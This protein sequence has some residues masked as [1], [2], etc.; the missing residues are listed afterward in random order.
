MIRKLFLAAIL[1]GCGCAHDVVAQSIT[2]VSNLGETPFSALA[3]RGIGS[4]GGPNMIGGEFVTG[5]ASLGYT[6]DSIAVLMSDDNG[7]PGGGF[8]VSV[9]TD[10]SGQPG[11]IVAML[12]GN[13]D[14]AMAGTYTYTA[15]GTTLFPLTSYWVVET[16]LSA[17]SDPNTFYLWSTTQSTSFAS[18]EGWSIVTGANEGSGDGGATWQQQASGETPMF[19]VAATAVPEPG[20]I[21][22]LVLGGA[23]G[24]LWRFRCFRKAEISKS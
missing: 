1:I 17:N 6:L 13:S 19:S 11:T 23:M 4:G 21:A 18:S 5:T 20:E 15:S 14:P 7:T 2:Y 22:L 3:V 9:Y 8:G 24:A 16:S 12:A 10:N